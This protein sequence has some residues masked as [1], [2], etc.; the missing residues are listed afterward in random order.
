MEL[1]SVV[2]GITRVVDSSEVDGMLLLV[3]GDSLVTVESVGTER[4]DVEPAASVD[5]VRLESE[6]EDISV[7]AVIC[8]VVINGVDEPIDTLALGSPEYAGSVLELT[9]VDEGSASLAVVP[10]TPSEVLFPLVVDSVGTVVVDWDVTFVVESVVV[11]ET[12]GSVV[13]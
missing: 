7:L 12:P 9:T 10:G 2:F 6:V 1:S 13:V 5:D 11:L 3:P 8:S 4:V